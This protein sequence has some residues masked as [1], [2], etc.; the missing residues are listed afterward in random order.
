[1]TI[2]NS[3]LAYLKGIAEEDVKGLTEADAR[4]GDSWL[5]RGGVGAYF[6]TIRK[7]DRLEVEAGNC[8]FD[9][10]KTVEK[11]NG[12]DGTLDTI[13]DLR[14]YLMLIEAEIL[15]RQGVRPNLVH[16]KTEV[17]KNVEKRLNDGKITTPVKSL[18]ERADKTEQQYP[19]GYQEEKG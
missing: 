17:I 13:R 16:Q 14:R 11:Y 7:V 4:Y 19:F 15:I 12:K 10:F 2:N 18:I 1:M 9:I 5:K 6:V 8:G 3:H